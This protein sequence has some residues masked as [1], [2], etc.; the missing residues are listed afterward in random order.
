MNNNNF[1]VTTS[2]LMRESAIIGTSGCSADGFL[3]VFSACINIGSDYFTE[4][5]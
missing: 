4:N 2:M 5:F 1:V 3:V